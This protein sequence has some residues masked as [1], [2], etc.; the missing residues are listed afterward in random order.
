MS[1]A[2]ALL[3][4]VVPVFLVVGAG[5]A[6]ARTGFLAGAAI[7]ALTAFGVRVGIP[8]LLFLALLR[9]DLDRAVD[10]RALLAFFAAI[11]IAFF[12]SMALS[13]LVWRRRPGESVAVGFSAFFGNVVML[14]IPIADRAYGGEVTAAVFG[15][16]AFHSA[17]NY[18][19]GFVAMEMIRSDGSSVWT[20]LRRAFVTTA[21]NPLMW[22]LAGIPLNLAG[23]ALPGIL[24]EGLDL[25]AAAG[26]P[27]ALFS[28]GGVLTRYRLRDEIGEALMVSGRAMLAL[29]ALVWLLTAGVFG[30]APEFVRA[31]VILAAMPPGLNGYIF[32]SL[33]DRAVGT[34]ASAVLLGTILSIGSITFW[35]A[36]LAA[37]S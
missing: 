21:R 5:Y 12:A 35:L 23:V 7:D 9:V 20:G 25:L 4:I 29:P 22:S 14:G 36:L 2:L 33:Y 26:I 31:A 13:R 17:H 15:L 16:I 1:T 37:W 10:W 32:A 8:A 3:E 30:L 27:V 6:S 19:F 34:A 11:I 24:L 28:L 18:F